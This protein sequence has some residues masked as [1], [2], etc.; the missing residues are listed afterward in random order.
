MDAKLKVVSLWAEDIPE[1]AHFY[2]DVLGLQLMP[3]HGDRPH[4]DLGDIY[5]VLVQGKPTVRVEGSPDYFPVLAFAVN[6]LDESI[7]QLRNHDVELPWDVV[8]G[9]GTRWIMFRDPAGNLIELVEYT[10]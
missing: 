3:H 8:D 4:F 10:S 5:L 7:A 2:R 6:N 1:T 9:K